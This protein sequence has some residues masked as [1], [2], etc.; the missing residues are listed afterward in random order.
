MKSVLNLPM[1]MMIVVFLIF[2]GLAPHPLDGYAFFAGVFG[3]VA[4]GVLDLVT[5]FDERETVS[6]TGAVEEAQ[7]DE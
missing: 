2:S 6:E 5:W 1:C 3:L 4:C 7:L